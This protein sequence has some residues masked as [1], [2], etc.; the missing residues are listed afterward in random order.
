MKKDVESYYKIRDQRDVYK[1]YF[2]NVTKII[3]NPDFFSVYDCWS[4]VIKEH[5]LTYEKLL[6]LGIRKENSEDGT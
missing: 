5:N 6:L 3:N 4:S 1:R 2:D